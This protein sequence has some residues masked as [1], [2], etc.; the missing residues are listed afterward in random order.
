MQLNHSSVVDMHRPWE[1][2]RVPQAAPSY[3]VGIL[4]CMRSGIHIDVTASISLVSIQM[5]TARKYVF[6]TVG[7]KCC[8]VD[9]LPLVTMTLRSRENDLHRQAPLTP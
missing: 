2:S 5:L 6:R 7:N 1:Q 3:V 8:Q 9:K 4:T